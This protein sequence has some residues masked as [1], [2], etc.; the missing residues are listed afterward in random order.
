[1]KRLSRLHGTLNKVI[2]EA[3]NVEPELTEMA[4]SDLPAYFREHL[5]EPRTLACIREAIRR[6]QGLRLYDVQLFA[7]L[8]MMR[9]HIA[10]M[11]TGEGKTLAAALPAAAGAREGR[12]VHV[13]TVNAYLAERDEAILRPAYA[14]LG[15]RSACVPEQG[16]PG[17]K[18]R[19]RYGCHLRHRIRIWL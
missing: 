16:S 14:M 18:S 9:G 10:E 5:D 17:E 4:A 19:L 11:A 3:A 12:G 6:T 15:L 13:A 1:M 8:V 2:Q 7:G